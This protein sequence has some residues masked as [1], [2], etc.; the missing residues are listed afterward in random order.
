GPHPLEQ[1]LQ[2]FGDAEEPEVVCDMGRYLCPGDADDHVKVILRGEKSPTV[3]LEISS[4]S[5]YNDEKWNILGSCGG[6]AGSGSQLRWKYFGPAELPEV[7]VGEGAAAGSKYSRVPLPWKDEFVEEVTFDKLMR[8]GSV[9]EFYRNLYAHLREGAPLAITPVHARRVM[10]VI[11]KCH[12][13]A[14]HRVK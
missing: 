14:D 5:A 11:Q 6:L 8:G 4:I 13:L 10:A 1:A 7:S 9:G 3:D 12:D 2:L